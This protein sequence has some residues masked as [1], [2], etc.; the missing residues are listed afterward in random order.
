MLLREA[1]YVH[2]LQHSTVIITSIQ[3]HSLDCGALNR[4]IFFN[5]AK[6]SNDF[7]FFVI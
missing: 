5:Q 7:I 3:D 1:Y 4:I 6:I 2:V